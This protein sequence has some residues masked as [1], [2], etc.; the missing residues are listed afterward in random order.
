M[1]MPPSC[2]IHHT[3]MLPSEKRSG[4][5]GNM[6]TFLVTSR[7]RWPAVVSRTSSWKGQKKKDQRAIVTNLPGAQIK[8]QDLLVPST[9]HTPSDLGLDSYNQ[10][11]SIYWAS[12]STGYL[13]VRKY[14][15]LSRSQFPNLLCV[16]MRF[17]WATCVDVSGRQTSASGL[18]PCPSRAVCL[19]GV[20]HLFLQLSVCLPAGDGTL[21]LT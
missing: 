3:S 9:H 8:P 19:V 2:T 21:C 15:S 11:T 1:S 14:F 7:A 17:M 4:F 16:Y 13:T 6:E 18:L 20:F 5:P 12:S 10:D